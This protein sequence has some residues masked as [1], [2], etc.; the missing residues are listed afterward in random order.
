[1]S[2]TAIVQNNTI[3]LPPGVDLPDGT[4]VRIDA[5]GESAG[6]ASVGKEPQARSPA[7]AWLLRHA[8]TIDTLPEDFAEHHDDYIRGRKQR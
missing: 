2:I 6:T 4:E 7:L 3:K 8:G 1:M 5:P